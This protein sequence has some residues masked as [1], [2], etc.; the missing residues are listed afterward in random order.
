MANIVTLISNDAGSGNTTFAFNLG[1]TLKNLNA[2]ILLVNFK[3]SPTYLNILKDPQ[4]KLNSRNCIS[5]FVVAEYDKRFQLLFLSNGKTS[6]NK[7]DYDK[8]LRKQI[9]LISKYFDF[10]IFDASP[11]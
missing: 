8:L 11:T 10:I 2:K 3:Y 9:G 4:I 1:Y 6:V 5:P 7:S